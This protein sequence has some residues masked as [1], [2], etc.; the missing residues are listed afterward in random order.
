MQR[1]KT[2]MVGGR[3]AAL[4]AALLLSVADGRA[5]ERNAS[6]AARPAPISPQRA[7]LVRLDERE[8]ADEKHAK[9]NSAAS[10]GLRLS[11]G[12]NGVF[13]AGGLTAALS[14][15][16]LALWLSARRRLTPERR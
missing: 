3:V 8:S 7:L 13:R 11:L 16:C 1:G 15:A 12:H 14:I 5:I 9:D 10:A 6:S 2:A 4:I